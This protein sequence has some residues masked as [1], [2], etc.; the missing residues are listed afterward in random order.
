M[1]VKLY[2]YA[3]VSLNYLSYNSEKYKIFIIK[4]LLHQAY[5]TYLLHKEKLF[6]KKLKELKNI[7]S[8]AITYKELLKESSKL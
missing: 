7:R 6:I 3:C 8:S 2:M 4:T 5:H 1:K